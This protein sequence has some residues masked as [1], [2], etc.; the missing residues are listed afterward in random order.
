MGIP[1]T[2]MQMKRLLKLLLIFTLCAVAVC[3]FGYGQAPDLSY[4]R[5][6]LPAT[7]GG[8][9]VAELERL[10][11]AALKNPEAVNNYYGLAK[12]FA[13]TSER[14]WAVVYAEAYC[15]HTSDAERFLEISAVL[16]KIYQSSLSYKRD[17]TASV[18][19]MHVITVGDGGVKVPF[20]VN[21]EMS[22]LL[23][24][25]DY[26][27]YNQLSIGTIHKIREGQ[28]RVWKEKGLPVHGWMSWLQQLSSAGMLEAYDYWL[29][30]KFRPVE[31]AGWRVKN[32]VKMAEFLAWRRTHQFDLTK[33]NFQ[34]LH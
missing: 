23:G 10:E 27:R 6:I 20:E 9:Q 1:D 18:S 14:V 24:F 3:K 19:F 29:L 8:G 30:Q 5:Q 25:E 26:E 11:Q 31:Y 34:R 22:T 2:T 17:G 16:G 4:Y 13:T 32:A 28:I 15:S 33:K 21:F 7:A 12:G